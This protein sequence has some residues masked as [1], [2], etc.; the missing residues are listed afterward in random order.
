MDSIK[1]KNLCKAYDQFGSENLV[2]KDITLSLPEK[3]LIT[4]M[5]PSG[6]GKS[7]FLNILS[8]LDQAKSGE[9]LV[10][11][12]NI[13]EFS[14]TQLT[15]YRR[16]TIGIVFQF[17]HLLPYLT[18]LENVSVPL[19]LQGKKQKTAHAI[20]A[21][22]LKRVGLGNKLHSK[23]RELSGGEQQRVS[24]S[25]AIVHNPKLILADEPTGNL[26]TNSTHEVMELLSNLV[27]DHSMTLLVV[28]HNPEIGQRGDINLKMLDGVI[29]SS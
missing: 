22:I 25:R 26:D 15:L 19:L 1:I 10:F 8:G 5:G 14:E 29:H 16:N 18:A 23:P 2:L 9:V 4:L 21:E 17:F 6:C 27:R 12:E 28:T 24:I 11:G 20:S 3:K 7:T 13:L